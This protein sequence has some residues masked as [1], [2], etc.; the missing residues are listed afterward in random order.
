VLYDI[1]KFPA[2]K[3]YG[4]PVLTPRGWRPAD[5][6]TIAK[7]PAKT[8]KQRRFLELQKEYGK[9]NARMNKVLRFFKACVQERGGHFYGQFHQTRTQTHR[10]SSTARPTYFK[11]LDAT[12][13]VQLQNLPREYKKLFCSPHPDYLVVECDGAQLEFRVAGELG[14]D[15]QVKLD[16]ENGEDIH[17]FSA[18][19]LF[20]KP[21]DKVTPKERTAAKAETFKP[22]YGGQSG[23]DA[24]VAYYKAFRRKYNGVYSTQMG[25]VA[26]VLRT[27]RLEMPWGMTFYFPNARMSSDGYC[28][29]TPSIFNYPVQCLATAEIIPISLTFL[30]WR[31]RLNGM[32]VKIVNTVHD[33]V[34]ALVRKDVISEYEEL[35]KTAFFDDTYRYLDLVYGIRMKV[36]L[37]LGFK[38]GTH[39]GQGEEHKYQKHYEEA[40]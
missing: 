31:G 8:K 27:K 33:S 34:I 28:R 10:T 23:S 5:R 29:D 32:P 22:L 24:Q 37:G 16:V 2:P 13:G 26:E 7:L 36:P 40:A 18:S 35:C 17:L 14:Q 4:K 30:Y 11:T 25:W 19:A 3:R 20:N 12:L 6:H 39:W 38:A 1:L 21:Q 9:M 15:S